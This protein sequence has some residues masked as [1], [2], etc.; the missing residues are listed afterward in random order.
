LQ[1]FKKFLSSLFKKLQ[2][3]AAPWQLFEEKKLNLIKNGFFILNV[4]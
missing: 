1:F 3:L 2:D 4:D